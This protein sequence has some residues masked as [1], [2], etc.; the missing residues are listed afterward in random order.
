MSKGIPEAMKVLINELSRLPSI[1]EKSASRLAYF[2]VTTGKERTR[3]LAESIVLAQRNVCYCSECFAITDQPV[4]AICLNVDRDRS[5]MCVVEKPADVL[6][7][8]RSGA[9][10]GIYHVLHGLW[11][12]L[13]G[14][15]PQDIRIAEIAIRIANGSRDGVPIREIIVATPT[16]VEG[17][18][19]ALYI[20][21]SMKDADVRISRLARG[22]PRGGDLEYADEVTLNYALEGRNKL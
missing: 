11:S 13:R 22:L 2:L 1:G 10:C 5:K 16:T 18:A 9:F 12:P 4:C 7:L 6:A 19:T 17:D 3:N 14:I 20:S 21:E 15:N 8:E